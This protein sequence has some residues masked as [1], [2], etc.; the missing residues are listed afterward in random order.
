MV[1]HRFCRHCKSPARGNPC[2]YG[3]VCPQGAAMGFDPP[4]M[5]D[6]YAEEVWRRER[7][8]SRRWLLLIAFAALCLGV[9][10]AAELLREFL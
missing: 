8:W 5:C 4:C 10:V 2:W 1:S 9:V 6:D 3:I 7:R